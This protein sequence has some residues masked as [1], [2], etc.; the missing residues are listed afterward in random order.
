MSIR[1]RILGAF[2]LVILLTVLISTGFDYW[3]G[4]K[5]LTD[6]STKIRTEDLADI[7][8]KQYTQDKSWE[9]LDEI[10]TRYGILIDPAKIQSADEKG[11]DFFEKI[12]WRVVVKDYEGT[13]LADTYAGLDQTAIDLQMEGDPAIIR[14]IDTSQGVGTV[15]VAINRD[16]VTAESR[17]FL[18]SILYPRLIQG[19]ITA[20]IAMLLGVW[21]SRRIT[22]PVIALT[23]AT[24]TIAQSGE[25]QF[26]PVNSS[27][28]LGQMSASF[29]QMMT[30][31]ETQRDLRNRL[32]DDV[33]H[34]LNTPLSVI[35]L[36]AKGLKD[37]IKPP[38]DAA[39]QIIG[40]VDLLSN[41]VYDLNWLAETDLGA[42]QLEMEEHDMGH[43]LKAEVER[44]QL[45]A[46]GSNIELELRSL[47]D[48]LPVIYMDIKRINQVLGNL[49]ENALQH[50]LAGGRVTVECQSI[51]D[52]LGTVRTE[53]VEV[54][55][56][57]TGAGIPA[58]DLPHVFER[59][60]RA[61]L[62]RQNRTGGRGLGLA[63][64]N[65]IM[66]VHQG[67]VWVESELGS[68]SCFYIRLPI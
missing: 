59:F 29:N 51:D 36:E 66:E 49:I 10:L 7:L 56:C 19:F 23:K 38:N 63:I 57:D 6:F 48:D 13:I 17:K 43:L 30:S 37:E 15:T 8:S 42:L 41:L 39:D 16:Y 52:W 58:E 1:W 14:D 34:E 3:T 22:A 11:V 32:I 45:Q 12:P 46:Q 67:E 24:Q 28:E 62:S 18:A 44:W 65:Q 31:L 54:S 4:A 9:N 25:T 60:Y 64:V 35:R 53:F 68:G 21:L 20:M 26:L 40:E 2:L 27:D 33:A 5:E 47:P 50:T 61:D 55:V